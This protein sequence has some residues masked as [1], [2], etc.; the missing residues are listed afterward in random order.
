MSIKINYK[1]VDFAVGDRIRVIQ[2][3][4]EGGKERSQSFEGILIAIKGK[5]ENKTITVRKLGV[6]QVGIERI[7]PLSSP[8][9]EKVEVLKKG[10]AGVRSAKLYYIRT[11]SR[12]EIEKIYKRSSRKK[13]SE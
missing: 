13:S 7:F 12:R 4:K 8:Y 11:K 9:L 10:S 2:K 1:S 6:Q 3:I 5:A